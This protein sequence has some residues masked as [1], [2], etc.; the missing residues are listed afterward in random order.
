MSAH[1]DQ[2]VLNTV[3]RAI[4][5]AQ[6]LGLMKD[7]AVR[8]FIQIIDHGVA[9]NYI[10]QNFLARVRSAQVA[11][12]M[13][14]VPFDSP[15]DTPKGVW[16]G[17]AINGRD[18][19][20]RYHT[21]TSHLLTVGG[22]G[23][24]KTSRLIRMALEI[25]GR[26][27]GCWWLNGSK[28]DL[29][30]LQPLLEPL[31][32]PVAILRGHDFRINILQPPDGVDP[33]TWASTICELIA[34]CTDLPQ[35]AAK[36]LE[37]AVLSLYA[38]RG[39]LSHSPSNFP[40][41]WD[42]YEL[43][44]R[45]DTSAVNA[46]ARSAALD[47]LASLMSSMGDQVLHNTVGWDTGALASKKFLAL[48]SDFN[49][50]S[51][52]VFIGWIGASE[53]MRRI[54]AGIVNADCDLYIAIDDAQKLVSTSADHPNSLPGLISLC[55]SGGICL[56]IAI[57]SAHGLHPAIMANAAT[58][59]VGRTGLASD[60]SILGSAMGLS[61]DQIA[62]AAHSLEVGTW[63]FQGAEAPLRKPTLIQIPRISIPTRP[64]L[65]KAQVK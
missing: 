24:G 23:S 52:N 7:E 46:M 18:V 53:L 45:A 8:R 51:Q 17:K 40:T 22:S 26:A 20:I 61:H 65:V 56:D 43:L 39:V 54:A 55:R 19:Y 14:G 3:Q 33:R 47:A 1:S 28:S 9:D 29:W 48:L 27:Q 42:V 38:G 13:S 64:K 11:R 49:T 34:I 16:V 2:S 30:V 59:Y 63:I 4:L 10:I 6:E 60:L 21:L 62:W 37:A 57:Q 31:G 41:L 25:A 12:A 50:A 35:R 58:R 32:I 44:R 36:L 5:D 15:P